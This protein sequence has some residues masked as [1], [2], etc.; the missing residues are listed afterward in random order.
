MADIKTKLACTTTQVQS[1]SVRFLQSSSSSLKTLS[2]LPTDQL[3]ILLTPAIP[4]TDGNE[5]PFECLGRALSKRHARVR[6]VPF[7][8][9]VGLTD[10]H[11]AW[12]RKAG[13]II[14]VNCDPTLMIDTKAATNMSSQI[15]VA[16]DVSEIAHDLHGNS[17]I[18]LSYFY[19]SPS[20]A[21]PTNMSGYDNVV[22]C[23]SY[24]IANMEKAAAM[25]IC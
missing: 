14:V 13:A 18:P 2:G 1:S 22:V 12:I 5:D 8:A 3:V 19:I 11:A 9:K 6:H 25:L 24:S 15:K 20:A 23:F 7:V 16:A 4:S 17:Q 21:A 10:L